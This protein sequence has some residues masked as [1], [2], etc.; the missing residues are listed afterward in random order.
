MIRYLGCAFLIANLSCGADPSV[1]LVDNAEMQD[2]LDE[3]RRRMAL[4]IVGPDGEEGSMTAS[5]FVGF[6]ENDVCD[7]E[8][9]NAWAELSE[10]ATLDSLCR[11][12][13]DAQL[14][15]A[16]CVAQLLLE[17]SENEQPLDQVSMVLAPAGGFVA[18][19]WTLPPQLPEARI[20][21][22]SE[23]ARVAQEAIWAAGDTIRESVRI[24]TASPTIN[25]GR[26]TECD[27]ENLFNPF[28]YQGPEETE[29]ITPVA[30]VA[31]VLTAASGTLQH[32]ISVEAIY[33][34]AVAEA[35]RSRSTSPVTAASLGW[36][37]QDM[38][39]VSFVKH[40]LGGVSRDYYG[41]DEG[42]GL[43]PVD[44]PDGSVLEGI[45]FLRSMGTDPREV[46]NPAI[47]LDILALGGAGVTN[48]F[49][50]RQAELSGDAPVLT[51]DAVFNAAGVRPAAISS[52]R[53]YLREEARAFATLSVPMESG[54]PLS[55][56]PDGLGGV[57][58][59]K[60]DA[61]AGLARPPSAPPAMYYIG[62]A[63][64]PQP[65]DVVDQGD[66]G[67]FDAV[68]PAD[69]TYAATSF[70]ATLDFA[71]SV[72]TDHAA[73]TTSSSEFDALPVDARR[74]LRPLVETAAT[75]I[76]ARVQVCRYGTTLLVDVLGRDSSYT[77]ASRLRIVQGVAGLRCAVDGNVQ[78]EACDLSSH[79]VVPASSST[80]T[81]TNRIGG[82]QTYGSLVATVPTVGTPAPN[83]LPQ[84]AA[85]RDFIYI[86]RPT[87]DLDDTP[88]AYEAIG[89][90]RLGNTGNYCV[91]QPVAP[92]YNA[93]A[94]SMLRPST[95][96]CGTTAATCAGPDFAERIPLENEITGDDGGQGLENSWQYWLGLA[97]DTANRADL[98]GESLLTSGEVLDEGIELV[99]DSLSELCGG[100]VDFRDAYFDMLDEAPPGPPSPSCASGYNEVDGNC[101]RDINDLLSGPEYETLRECLGAES[102]VDYV[103]AGSRPLCAW[104]Y[105]GRLCGTPDYDPMILPE[106]QPAYQPCP[107]VVD[108][109]TTTC[110]AMAVPPGSTFILPIM[111]TLGIFETD[112]PQGLQDPPPTGPFDCRMIRQM[113]N[114]S[115]SER[116]DLAEQMIEAPD[117]S[118]ERVREWAARIGY[119][120]FPGDY[121]QITLDNRHW[122]SLGLPQAGS[123]VPGAEWPCVSSPGAE[124][125]ADD[126]SLFCAS[127]GG[128]CGSDIAAD[129]YERAFMNHRMARAV[130]ALKFLTGRSATNVELPFR[131]EPHR[132]STEAD[133]DDDNELSVWS[134]ALRSSSD[135]FLIRD[136]SSLFLGDGM[137]YHVEE[138]DAAHDVAD[139]EVEGRSYCLGDAEGWLWT[140]F[141]T[142]GFQNQVRV[143]APCDHNDVQFQDRNNTTPIEYTNQEGFTLARV[144]RTQ[145]V[146][147]RAVDT[148][149]SINITAAR[150]LWAGMGSDGSI[151]GV[152]HNTIPGVLR[153]ETLGRFRAA[154]GCGW[155][156]EEG[157]VC[158]QT[159]AG[160]LTSYWSSG[161]NESNRYN[162]IRVMD[163][164]IVARDVLDGLE[165]LCE[166]Q[167]DDFANPS[168]FEPS[169]CGEWDGMA[170]GS[171]SNLRQAQKLMNCLA[172]EIESRGETQVFQNLPEASLDVIRGA[173]TIPGTR[174]E[175]L[176]LVSQRLNEIAAFPRRIGS[177]L[178][179]A[180]ELM[181]QARIA[182]G[183]NETRQELNGLERQSTQLRETMSCL[184]SSARA[185]GSA[186]NGV[187]SAFAAGAFYA[188]AMA[189]CANS[190]G[191]IVIA[192]QRESLQN[193][194]SDFDNQADLSRIQMQLGAALDG[195]QEISL[196][197]QQAQLGLRGA[198]STLQAQRE[199]A[200]NEVADALTTY[201]NTSAVSTLRRRRHNTNQERYQEAHGR[202][203]GTAWLARRALEQRIGR[204]L[205]TMEDDLPL[206][207]APNEWADTLCTMGG[208]NYQAI[209][210]DYELPGGDS[211]GREYVGDYVRRLRSV[212]DSYSVAYPFVTGDDTAVVSLRD[213]VV[214]ARQQC[215]TPVRNLLAYSG[216]LDVA[217][218]PEFVAPPPESDG[219]GTPLDRSGPPIWE[220]AGCVPYTVAVDDGAG[221]TVNVDRVGGCI[222]FERLNDPAVGEVPLLQSSPEL[223]SPNGWSVTFGGASSLDPTESSYSASARVAQKVL[224]EPGAYR[225]S[226]R[227]RLNTSGFLPVNA[228]TVFDSNGVELS[229]IERMPTAYDDGGW[230]LYYLFFSLGG[231][232][233]VEV[234]I[235][236]GS[237]IASASM[238]ATVDIGALM[239]E[240][241][242]AEVGTSV[243]SFSTDGHTRLPMPYIQTRT[244]GMA[245]FAVC[246]D[247][248][249]SVFR[250][251]WVR[252]C[253]RLCPGGG[254]SCAEGRRACFWELPFSISQNDLEYGG[255]LANA[256]FA[257]GNYNYRWNTMSANVVGV[258]VRDCEG[259]TSPSSCYGAGYLPYSLYHDGGFEV[260]NH[261]GDLYDAPLH[262]GRLE[263]ARALNA[264]RFITNPI[265][266][267]DRAL[268]EPYSRYEMRGRPLAGRYRMRIWDEPGIRFDRIEDVQVVLNYRYWTRLD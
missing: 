181:R 191:Q 74:R 22:A 258:S 248:D 173:G 143:F 251:R 190:I 84:E 8:M 254:A 113:R 189:D 57:E 169:T 175:Q 104:T 16:D 228:V 252:D 176:I 13:L 37:N 165:L 47:D 263:H 28:S 43:C 178:R 140:H 196:S 253:T 52:A 38:S 49:A 21:L 101:V 215:E 54:I 159:G 267:A 53:R 127:A 118:L 77:D 259:S 73:A 163:D 30:L 266:S 66:E 4:T 138:T 182:A 83:E 164:G 152:G 201:G 207:D 211:Y 174:G 92:S 68:T 136:G 150:V 180:S 247:T 188:A 232:D 154:P 34:T 82:F 212:F 205:S 241:I 155:R 132:L 89:V 110:S 233:T 200:M 85:G 156:D 107:W 170:A 246:E 51:A 91:K 261:W 244:P 177:Q 119:R 95:A 33:Q 80:G 242:T 193:D 65:T 239:L 172:H 63:W 148:S 128:T 15:Q 61:W 167:Q 198:L 2:R 236:D 166:V 265:S 231:T 257:N 46:L 114:A 209:T 64:Q 183:R 81:S 235:Q 214:H 234:A 93:L 162:D 25:D 12:A 210:R 206:V 97:E 219:L 27:L 185:V 197:A 71:V 139:L 45:R 56:V 255:Q 105:E 225:L 72:A 192:K 59:R 149:A 60:A 123:S 220:Q 10:L 129:R 79:L 161:T 135:D 115:G 221:G 250:S 88:G 208:M 78:G 35:E 227:G 249:G 102:V 100:A 50:D 133:H 29:S 24:A 116:R 41:F 199:G 62:A 144:H 213:D 94:G 106:N 6:L 130:L 256:G 48:S 96:F 98:L 44:E 184:S 39:R 36:V 146:V 243:A 90:H 19:H 108:D 262:A 160:G 124:C 11:N 1:L 31:E 126:S 58:E 158:D 226:W 145:G 121:G 14:R 141:P 32:A 40:L 55:P 109:A 204:S 222:G 187:G 238:P 240:D 125:V 194:L 76:P 111:R 260:R 224:L 171:I 202:A 26:I 237:N 18:E 17:A 112:D 268:V 245:Q 87:G 75:R 23:A 131:P 195:L 3:R 67:F 69:V 42:E 120:G 151:E 229:T 70:V 147:F 179:E 20:A 142:A 86:L 223:G 134:W 216:E 99:E 217:K 186:T 203:I 117:F 218:D 230:G 168:V 264:E 103:A 137:T 7:A 153:G 122:R 5:E 9:P 157:W